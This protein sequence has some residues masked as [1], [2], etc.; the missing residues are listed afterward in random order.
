MF[1]SRQVLADVNS[2]FSGRLRVISGW[3]FRYLA[4]E[5]ILQ[6]GALVTGIWQDALKN[7]A[8]KNKSWLVLGIAGGSV[9]HIISRKYRPAHITAVDIDPVM[10]ELGKK[11]FNFEKISNLEIVNLDANLYV[12]QNKF[13]FDYLLVDLYLD[14][15]YPPF[16]QQSRFINDLKKIGKQIYFNRLYY[17]ASEKAAAQEFTLWLKKFFTIVKPVRTHDNLVLICS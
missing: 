3:G 11:F 15:R 13:V 12:S 6:S 10:I 4:S 14:D 2:R 9:L 1:S 16:V 5:K 7:S 17:T 8:A